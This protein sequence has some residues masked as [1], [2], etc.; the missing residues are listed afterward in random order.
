MVSCK[1]I[2]GLV[3][4]G[5][6][7]MR[8]RVRAMLQFMNVKEVVQPNKGRIHIDKEALI[9]EVEKNGGMIIFD[10]EGY[11]KFKEEETTAN[12]M[13]DVEQIKRNRLGAPRREESFKVS[14]QNMHFEEEKEE[15]EESS[16]IH[17]EN[18][19]PVT[20]PEHPGSLEQEPKEDDSLH[21]QDI[22][23]SIDFDSNDSQKIP[24]DDIH[25]QELCEKEKP[26]SRI[27]NEI[28]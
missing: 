17:E 13:P 20:D 11:R 1:T 9:C 15:E 2:V 22:E 6:D 3:S 27:D 8:K 14:R 28:N 5:D 7:G 12:A 26:Q 21:R 19:A 4:P 10:S 23:K 18:A 16:E 25:N 24:Q